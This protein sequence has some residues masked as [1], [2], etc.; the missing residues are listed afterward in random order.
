MSI[1]IVLPEPGEGGREEGRGG[2]E[3]REGQREGGTERE[4][5]GEGE[6]RRERGRKRGQKEIRTKINSHLP[7]D[8]CI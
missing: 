8:P 4:I 5:V 7:T 6:R 2:R 1:S 3:G